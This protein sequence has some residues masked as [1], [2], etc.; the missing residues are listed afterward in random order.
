MT[1][2]KSIEAKVNAYSQELAEYKVRQRKPAPLIKRWA[3]ESKI[4]AIAEDL[5]KIITG[6]EPPTP[7]TTPTKPVKPVKPQTTSTG[8]STGAS[9]TS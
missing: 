5:V 2:W 9:S 3:D 1:D 7:P 8:S 6:Q 4:V